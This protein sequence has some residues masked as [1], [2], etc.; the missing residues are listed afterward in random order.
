MSECFESH[1]NIKSNV[2][3]RW[4]TLYVASDIDPTCDFEP[5][6]ERTMRC[7]ATKLRRS[8]RLQMTFSLKLSVKRHDI[9]ST[10]LRRGLGSSMQT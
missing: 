7:H 10:T 9:T 3:L 6:N 1:C 5:M 2:I 8:E 4:E